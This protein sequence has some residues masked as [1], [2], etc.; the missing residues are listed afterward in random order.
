MAIR[1]NGLGSL[2]YCATVE[3]TPTVQAA[4]ASDLLGRAQAFASSLS[5]VLR[6]RALAW[7][8][9]RETESS[10]AIEREAPSED[11]ARAFRR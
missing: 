1:F 6:E 11:K 9:L 2:G 4:M 10:F 3:R 5:P 7:A 8:Y